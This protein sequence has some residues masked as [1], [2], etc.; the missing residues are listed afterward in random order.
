[1]YSIQWTG[2]LFNW[3]I[4]G[5]KF[6]KAYIL[7]FYDAVLTDF[8]LWTSFPVPGYLIWDIPKKSILLQPSSQKMQ[9]MRPGASKLSELWQF[10]YTKVAWNLNFTKFLNLKISVN[11]GDRSPNFCMWSLNLYLN[12]MSIATWGLSPLHHWFLR[13][14]F[15]SPPP[16]WPTESVPPPW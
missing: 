2:I 16:L 10:L 4:M 15:R 7:I 9:K 13:G 3:I 12:N 5:M 14:G 11:F 6:Y 8:F 1:M